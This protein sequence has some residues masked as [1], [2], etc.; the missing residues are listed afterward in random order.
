MLKTL[1]MDSH[2]NLRDEAKWARSSP[3]MTTTAAL[4]AKSSNDLCAFGKASLISRSNRQPSESRTTLSRV[5][6]GGT[7]PGLIGRLDRGTEVRAELKHMER[8][9]MARDH[10]SLGITGIVT[11][12][13]LRSS[14][15]ETACVM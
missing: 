11:L 8:L 2:E 3:M 9:P 14:L 7:L 1:C 12:A 6:A 13:A 4:A 10:V 5:D 15:N